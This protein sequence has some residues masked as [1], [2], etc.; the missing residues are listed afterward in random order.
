VEGL[1]G[2]CC[3]EGGGF[4]SASKN[5]RSLFIRLF[6]VLLNNFLSS[7]AHGYTRRTKLVLLSRDRDCLYDCWVE[8]RRAGTGQK[9]GILL[10][11][12]LVITHIGYL[13]NMV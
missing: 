13:K 7:M 5:G 2:V 11:S 10:I 12:S 3:D 6:L 4:N 1:L 8:L 9:I